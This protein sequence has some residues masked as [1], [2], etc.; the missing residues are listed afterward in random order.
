MTGLMAGLTLGCGKAD[1]VSPSTP[2]TSYWKDVAPIYW[3]N[4]VSC[5]QQGGIAPFRLDRYEDA[6][7]WAQA[8]KAAVSARTMPP[9]L[10]TADGSCGEFSDAQWLTQ[11][12]IQTIAKWADS[13]AAQG[14]ARTDLTLPPRPALQNATRFQTPN[15]TPEI[16]GGDF[17]K[18]DEYRCFKVDPGLT[19]DAFLT[20]YDIL[21]GNKSLVHHVLVMSV[22]PEAPGDDGRTNAEIM[23]ELDEDSPARDGWPCFGLA[24]DNV[25]VLGVPVTWAPGMGVVDYPQGTGVRLPAGSQL[26]VQ[27]HYNLADE[28][29]R[30]QSDTSAIDLRLEPS[31]E[32]EGFFVLPDGFLD[33]LFSDQPDVLPAD[34][35]SVPYTWEM[36]FDE[37]IA[38][39]G[40]PSV[41]VWGVMPHMHERGKKFRMQVG[42]SCAAQVQRWDFDWQLFYFYE[43]PFSVTP[44]T[45]LSVTCDFDTTGLSAP[46]LPGWGTQNEMCLAALYV[47]PVIE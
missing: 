13:G 11:A 16:V 12:Q 44:G 40:I 23:T 28:A 10:V 18:F 15:F 29:I 33:T 37:E 43:K 6:K 24:G 7:T 32:R 47:V 46:V 25:D 21:P 39:F 38:A 20:G 14:E 22:H 1:P 8:S 35:A 26:V 2:Q 45:S 9:W 27:V 17:A 5:H 41:E 42:D 34:Q 3:Q 19:E 4:C 36:D 30:G 31:V